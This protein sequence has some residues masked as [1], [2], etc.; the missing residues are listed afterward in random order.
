MIPKIRMV[1]LLAQ[2]MDKGLPEKQ[3][4]LIN[5]SRP[6][7]VTVYNP[8]SKL[9]SQ[10]DVLVLLYFVWVFQHFKRVSFFG[11][12][13]YRIYLYKIYCTFIFDVL[14]CLFGE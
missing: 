10:V 13:P 11:L 1:T 12:K 5:L 6:K 9:H 7:R 8:V 2:S 14:F 3:K 4:W